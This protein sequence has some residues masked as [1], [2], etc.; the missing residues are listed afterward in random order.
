MSMNTWRNALALA[1]T[2]A[3]IAGLAFA[4]GGGQPTSPSTTDQGGAKPSD[5][6]S[7]STAPGAPSDAEKPQADNPD[8][9]KSDAGK[10]AGQGER[11]ARGRGQEQVRAVQQALKEKGQDPGPI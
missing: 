9:A 1:T 6:S 2:G 7:P 5:Q 10:G 4:Q 11:A 8:A 3:F